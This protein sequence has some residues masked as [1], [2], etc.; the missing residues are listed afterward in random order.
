MKKFVFQTIGLLILIIAGLFVTKNQDFLNT[1]MGENKLPTKKVQIKDIVIN[2]EIAEGKAEQS[3]GLSGRVS[4]ATNSGMLFIYK[5]PQIRRFWMKGM[6]FPIDII[7]INDMKVVDVLLDVKPP[8]PET[9]DKDLTIYQPNEP[10]DKVL[11]VY[12]G[13]VNSNRISIG[14][15]VIVEATNN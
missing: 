14:D 12:S 2:A 8:A 3:K 5:E 9:K 1:F 6:K 13:F 11:E 10:V 7:W 15:S 4:I